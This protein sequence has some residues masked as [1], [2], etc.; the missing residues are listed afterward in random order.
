MGAGMAV[1]AGAGVEVGAGVA[2]GTDA[3]LSGVAEGTRPDGA[4]GVKGGAGVG[5][6]AIRAI[7]S[8]RAAVAW[9]NAL[10]NWGPA[11]VTT[12]TETIDAS[13]SSTT[14]ST[15]ACPD[16]WRATLRDYVHTLTT[17]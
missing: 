15:R 6:G 8:A 11:T 14:Y 7:G 13:A 10:D 9:A 1:G 3:G 4:I 12:P 5:V 16:L 2:L 17:L